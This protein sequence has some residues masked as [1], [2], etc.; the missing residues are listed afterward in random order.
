MTRSCR[1][2]TLS[3]N[4]S[5]ARPAAGA[6]A[7]SFHESCRLSRNCRVHRLLGSNP[8]SLRLSRAA[9]ACVRFAGRERANGGRSTGGLPPLSCHLRN[10]PVPDASPCECC[11]RATCRG[12]ALDR[13]GSPGTTASPRRVCACMFASRGLSS[14]QQTCRVCASAALG[15]VVRRWQQRHSR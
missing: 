10:A 3:C 7:A 8:M 4:V 11:K 6:V 15:H 12:H 9:T 2:C 13:R 14:A 5:L 1:K